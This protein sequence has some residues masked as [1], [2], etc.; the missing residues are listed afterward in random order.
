MNEIKMGWMKQEINEWMKTRKNNRWMKYKNGWM[1][2]EIMN[3]RTMG[4]VNEQNNEWNEDEWMDK[5]FNERMKKQ[6]NEWM[7]YKNGW[8]KKIIMLNWMK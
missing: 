6:Y 1:K 7:E 4:G 3:E 8:M 2:K 5:D